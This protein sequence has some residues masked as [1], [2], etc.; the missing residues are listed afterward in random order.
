MNP[1]V[2]LKHINK[3]HSCNKQDLARLAYGKLN[4]PFTRIFTTNEGYKAICRNEED[5][6]KILNKEATKELEKI[7]IL[8]MV[9]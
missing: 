8:V 2:R 3:D 6:D 7:G 1:T 4:V 5:A 9:P